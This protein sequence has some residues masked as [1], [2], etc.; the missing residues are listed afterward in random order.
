LK[1][2][3]SRIVPDRDVE[4]ELE[5]VLSS[6][7]FEASER[8]RRFLSYVVEETLSGR[9]DRIKAYSIATR[10]FA[11][12]D[13]FDPVQDS[14]V[15]IEAGRLRRSL[16]YYYLKQG[17]TADVRIVIPKGT[18]VP[19]FQIGATTKDALAPAAGIAVSATDES[20]SRL[21]HELGPRIMVDN[22]EQEGD[23]PAYP[24]IARTL[25]RQVISALTRFTEVFVYGFDTTEIVGV[26]GADAG[27]R[28]EL[29]FDYELLGTVTMSKAA[30][31]AQ[32]LLRRAEDRRFVWTHDIER[33]LGGE[34][35]AG[36]V[37][38]LCAEIA[39]HIA[40]VIAQRDG[41]MDSQARDAAGAAP[42]HFSGYQKLLD[43]QDYWRSLD[44]D[45]FEPLRRDLE[46]TVGKDPHFAA[47]FACLSMLYTNA[48]RYGYS[49][50]GATRTPP[51]ERAMELART[52]I[53]LAPTSSRAYHA[54][55]VAEWF[56]GMP[57]Q[58]LATLQIAR[59]LNP[60]EPELL[61][62]L[63]FRSAMRMEWDAAVPLIEEAYLRNPLQSGQYRMGLFLYHFVA[64]RHE[65]A[66]N[67]VR[68]IDAP[69]IAVVHLAAAASLSGLGR[70]EEARERLDE[71]ARLAPALRPKL[72]EDLAFR[73]L[74]PELIAAI[75][76]A[77]GRIDSGW[78]PP[79]RAW[80]PGRPSLSRGKTGSR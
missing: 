56:S 9:S 53:R 27:R 70:L 48:A 21:L 34:P 1:A 19:E 75:T 22:F 31:S 30:L 45:L 33:R 41:I 20:P 6:P 61:A 57:D 74:H 77:I 13:D 29:T 37:A 58:G 60:N 62:E 40:S 5:R 49:Y 39:G 47:G 7:D 50:P 42:Q 17:D 32:L 24:T 72:M 65:Q 28:K 59:S 4:K 79:G 18:Y 51:L 52:A 3:N 12:G 8:N 68:A 76:E 78:L 15:R 26:R 10:V 67:E 2:E 38:S 23:S 66:L 71:V 16:E 11:R 35:D 46:A 44:P 69:G 55:A 80:L 63:G 36:Q 25:T 54:R 73:Q 64:G 14:I 43:F